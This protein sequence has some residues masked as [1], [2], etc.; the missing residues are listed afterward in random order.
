M[1]T[2]KTPYAG[3]RRQYRKTLRRLATALRQN[4]DATTT[5]GR[6]RKLL[7]RLQNLAR[8]LRTPFAPVL[9]AACVAAALSA[10]AL[11][12]QTPK[13]LELTPATNSHVAASAANIQVSFS[14]QMSVTTLSATNIA[15]HGAQ[16]AYLST[17]GT[18]SGNPVR[19]FNP[20]DNLR[21][22]ELITVSVT[23]AASLG[24]VPLTRAQVFQFRVGVS[25]GN[26]VFKS[27]AFGSTITEDGALGD[28]DGDGDLDAI[29]ATREAPNEVWLNNGNGTFT[30]STF[31]WTA[32]RTEAV[33]LGDL[34]NDGDL[35]AVFANSSQ[36]NEVWLNNGDAT[37]V[38][39]SIGTGWSQ[40]VALGDL[41]GDGDLDAVIANFSNQQRIW[42]NNGDATFKRQLYGE[43][44]SSYGVDFG[45][46]DNDGDLDVI[47]ANYHAPQEVWLN[48]GDGTF[49][50]SYAGHSSGFSYGVEMG[51]LDND[52]DMD[53]IIA[54]R[55]QSEIWI[56]NGDATFAT[57]RFG[58]SIWGNDV[59]MGDIDHDG[60]LDAIISNLTG[61]QQIWINNGDGTFGTSKFGPESNSSIG[62]AMGD[63]DGD[64][65]IDAVISNYFSPQE[66]WKNREFPPF[67]PFAPRI[68]AMSPATNSHAAP[69]NADI[70]IEFTR[71]MTTA[72]ITVGNVYIHGSQTG[73]LST[74]GTI[75]GAQFTSF[76]P[77]RKF[78]A[79]ELISVM[80]TGA[81]SLGGTTTTAPVLLAF[82]AGVDGGAAEFAGSDYGGGASLGLAFGDL[83]SDGDLDAVIA[84]YNQA[85]YILLNNG[86]ATFSSSTFGGF[87]KSTNVA[88]GDLD[89]DG[90]LDA[91]VIG[92]VTAKEIWLNNGDATFTSST[93]GV[94]NVLSNDIALGDLDNDGDLDAII[95]NFNRDQEIWYNNGDAT[96]ELFRDGPEDSSNSRGIDLGDLDGDG[97]L[98]AIIANDSWAP[99]E[100]WY[101]NGDGRFT[102]TTFGTDR[103]QDVAIGDLDGDGDLDAI[104]SNY[105]QSSK[106]WRNNGDG[107]FAESNFAGFNPHWRAAE[108]GDFDGDGDLD[109]VFANRKGSNSFYLN[110][111]AGNFTYR[112]SGGA[113]ASAASGGVAV[114]DLDRDGDLDI[115]FANLSKAQRIWINQ[116][117]APM[118]R[119]VSPAAAPAGAAVVAIEVRG[120]DFEQTT[121]Q[122]TTLDQLGNPAGTLT[123]TPVTATRAQIGLE[124][125]AGYFATRGTLTLTVGNQSGTTSTTISVLNDSPAISLDRNPLQIDEDNATEVIVSIGDVWPGFAALTLTAP[126]ADLTTI[127]SITQLG[128]TGATTTFRI[129]P[130]AN[131]FGSIELDFAVSDGELQSTTTLSL[132]VAPV[133][134]PPTIAASNPVINMGKNS[135]TGLSIGLQDIDT[136]YAALDV[137]AT[138]SNPTLLPVENIVF[139]ATAATMQMRLGPDCETVG[140]SVVTVTV[141]DGDNERSTTILVN[142]APG[143][144]MQITGAACACV[145]AVLTYKTRPADTS[146]SYVW[147][148]EGG[149]IVAGQ[150][151]GAIRV[152]WEHET[153]VAS[154]SVTRTVLTGCTSATTIQQTGKLVQA[155][156][157]FAVVSG[158]NSTTLAATANDTATNP[159]ILSV[160]TPQH[161]SAEV[162]ANS[163]VYAPTAGFGGSDS[164]HYII[165]DESGCTTAGLV[166]V[167][168][169]NAADDNVNLEFVEHERDRSG[170]VRGLRG[171]KAA[172][173]SPDGR[174]VYA[175]GFYDHSI[176]VF[177]RNL[178][179]GMLSFQTRVRNGRG[180]VS[181]LK[182]VSDVKISADGMRLYAAGYGDNA[183]A[184]FNRDINSGGLEFAERK[185]RGE[186]DDGQI[187]GGL[188]RPRRIAISPDGRT[189]V[190]TGYAD[191]SLALFRYNA[192]ADRMD[193]YSVKRDGVEGVDGLKQALGAAFSPDGRHLYVAGA[194]DDAIAVFVHDEGDL[195]Y[196]ERLR[197]NVGGVDGLGTVTDVYV[198]PDGLHVYAAGTGENAIAVFER[199]PLDGRLTYVECYKNGQ[200]GITGLAGIDGLVVDGSGALLWAAAEQDNSLTVFKRNHGSGTL[201]T[202]DQAKDGQSGFNGLA[203]AAMTALTSDGAHAYT[204]GTDDNAVAVVYR[205][206][207]AQAEND[208]GGSADINSTVTINVLNNDTDPDA[209]VLS[210]ASATDGTLGTTAIT[211][212]GTTIDYKAGASSGADQFTYTIEDGH[213]GSS[214]ATVTINITMPKSG[215]GEGPPSANNG[216]TLSPNPARTGSVAEF[217]LH[218]KAEV[219]IHITD[220]RGVRR[221][222]ID[223]GEL[224]GGTH[225]LNIDLREATGA[226]FPAGTYIVEL[227]VR[228]NRDSRTVSRTLIVR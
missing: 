196:V 158:T 182:Y 56:N 39:T 205:N 194:G 222:S 107:T 207:A 73:Y 226:R 92:D 117:Q 18:F 121:A 60:D 41:D 21:V 223:S 40:D 179:T 68:A 9:R 176:A 113:G 130:V 148:A 193:Y 55:P 190:A 66:V 208:T 112:T 186:T 149:T 169:Q 195:T 167:F 78:M 93:F 216:L 59:A 33:A 36:A 87:S 79:G 10:A 3:L 206:R 98:D 15:I 35:D 120:K 110:D 155:S 128:A 172:A 5:A 141:S 22:G 91:I 94:T 203:G 192:V 146:A 174:F 45:D 81:T 12:A 198:S 131:A 180:G 211:G 72:G 102:I 38:S 209:H 166:Q 133:N 63:L 53:A 106:L 62:V 88:L 85:Q 227:E 170:G 152:I 44:N 139:S 69:R 19:T 144:P 64:G 219:S 29:F 13:V 96:F 8:A 83:D 165:Q 57:S 191:H 215:I 75:T 118:I 178:S 31:G 115:M 84:N 103:S 58:P 17:R 125:P 76:N 199:N 16:S 42:L 61:Q 164:F 14:T 51:D 145:D 11:N 225:A 168:V 124:V 156:M 108:L 175:A 214:T 80:V 188:K 228:G 159:L 111:G 212:G 154:L 28:L 4:D 86:D 142:V 129:V 122:I 161:G 100:I 151:S 138:S 143:A 132:E 47:V 126:T 200:G 150:G 135:V 137:S 213:G 43:S 34:D 119:W 30:S 220:L 217:T 23:G 185:K 204:A 99:Q 37:F 197:D 114:G 71:V 26:G 82:R 140:Q 2:P 162:S 32:G 134:D 221:L 48:K 97:D 123:L 27:S 136:P 116:P 104:I 201:Q 101:N 127:A 20:D 187:I 163:I 90:D 181:G 109:V 95:T 54:G 218:E 70:N 224:P 6:R 25:R 184:V 160:G 50:S 46:L 105:N 67:N 171:A 52:G 202:A 183:V 24:G 74:R 210:I 49:V 157:D 153:T 7:R 177:S 189:I 89:N 173:V 65:D 1:Y 77:D 147:A